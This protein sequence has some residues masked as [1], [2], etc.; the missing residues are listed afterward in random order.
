[1]PYRIVALLALAVL[2]ASLQAQTPQPGYDWKQAGD[3]AR[4]RGVPVVVVITGDG[5]GFCERMRQEVMDDPE[6]VELL[7]KHSVLRTLDRNKGGKLR[8][9]DG[10]RIRARLFVSRYEVFAT[11]TLLFLDATGHPAAPA[12]VGYDDAE[13]Y[14]GLLAG[15]L[16][17]AEAVVRVLTPPEPA[18]ADH[19][20][21]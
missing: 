17:R 15:R 6:I 9:F 20:G 19:Q 12:L 8:D 1:M 7:E 21:H 18:L 10:D 3:A 5:C 13:S 2:A 14:R 4:A 16:T 11:P